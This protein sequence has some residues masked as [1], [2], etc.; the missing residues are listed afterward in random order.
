M[1]VPTTGTIYTVVEVEEDP[2]G[3]NTNLGRYTN[4]VN[5]LDLSAIAVPNGFYPNGLPVGVTFLA[6]AFRE[7]L[8]CRL[9]EAFHRG[10]RLTLGATRNEI[11]G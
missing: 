9:G 3:L 6:P 11:P 10:S 5:L 1:I 7:G 8:L 4:F 2:F